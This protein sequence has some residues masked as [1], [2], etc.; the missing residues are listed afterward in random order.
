MTAR[1]QPLLVVVTGAP[2]SGKTTLARALAAEI[3]LPLL[4]KDD[5]KEALFD[6]LGTGDCDWTRKL[7]HVRRAVRH[8]TAG[9]RVRSLVHPRIE[10]LERRAAP[11][12]SI[13]AGCPDLL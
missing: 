5:V 13:R 1:A 12:A 7:R 2:G 9:A 10:L 6:T 3:R 11:R 4:G 8:G